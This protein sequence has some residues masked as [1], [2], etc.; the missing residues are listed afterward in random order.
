MFAQACF[1]IKDIG[2]LCFIKLYIKVTFCQLLIGM[3]N[4]S[5]AWE[6]IKMIILYS[7]RDLQK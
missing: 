3:K 2:K 4:T 1:G 5:S 7:T 6:Y